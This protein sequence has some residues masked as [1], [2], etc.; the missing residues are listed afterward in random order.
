MNIL[1]NDP[2]YR[3]LPI[4]DIFVVGVHRQL[5]TQYNK[6]IRNLWWFVDAPLRTQLKGLIREY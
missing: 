2:V 4:E 5:N 3:E 1:K 6:K